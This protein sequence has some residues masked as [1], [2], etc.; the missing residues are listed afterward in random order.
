VVAEKN[1]N[2][3]PDDPDWCGHGCVSLRTWTCPDCDRPV[4]PETRRRLEAAPTIAPPGKLWVLLSG[5]QE[6][7]KEGVIYG[8]C[9]GIFTDRAKIPA[10]MVRGQV[11]SAEGIRERMRRLHWY[12][13]VL[14]VNVFDG[15][16]EEVDEDI[17][18][19][20][21]LSLREIDQA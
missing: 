15:W 13:G 18:E 14:N 7:V 4:T 5:P 16:E 1:W 11:D 20:Y 3:L 9:D 19:V 8:Y 6:F 10:L 17:A 12:Q 21:Y 2:A